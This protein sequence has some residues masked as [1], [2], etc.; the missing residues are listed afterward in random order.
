MMARNFGA[1]LTH[2]LAEL[3]SKLLPIPCFL[4]G[5][6]SFQDALCKACTEE[7]PWLGAHCRQCAMP[8]NVSGICGQCLQHPP[9]QQAS[10]ALFRYETPINH[11]IA[12]FKFHQQLVF[13]H[14]FAKLL[15]DK[16]E[17]RQ[18][19]L[20]EVIIPIPLHSSRLRQRGYN[21]SA[22]LADNLA[23]R[24]GVTADKYSLIRQRNTSPQA[25]LSR[26]QRKRNL[27]QAFAVI[28][29][30]P[31]KRVALIDD[32]YTTGHTVAEASRC[33][34]QNGVE[35]VEVWTIARA[36]RHY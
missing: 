25:G 7:L 32:V 12:A 18:Q 3:Y 28:K 4:C 22:Q 19:P 20:P 36:I 30:L 27:K 24:L 34:Q 5:E 10:L 14:L 16:I 33:L 11:C 29:P 23:K 9:P 17:Q 1:V 31:Y 6:F 13:T 26:K 8:L 15:V 21:Q 35:E 2:R